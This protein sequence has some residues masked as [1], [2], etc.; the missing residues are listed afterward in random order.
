MKVEFFSVCF[1]GMKLVLA[2]IHRKAPKSTNVLVHPNRWPGYGTL[3]RFKQCQLYQLEAEDHPPLLFSCS[4]VPC[5]PR[6]KEA[7]AA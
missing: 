4:L 7:I 2:S 6:K 1:C 3:P 5:K